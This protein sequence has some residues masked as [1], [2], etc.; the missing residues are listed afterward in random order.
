VRRRKSVLEFSVKQEKK[1]LQW[2]A[3]LEIRAFTRHLNIGM[4][5]YREYVQK[6]IDRPTL[7]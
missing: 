6:E 4:R 2:P 7:A 5:R 3:S 1:L